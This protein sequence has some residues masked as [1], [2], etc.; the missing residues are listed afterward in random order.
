MGLTLTDNTISDNVSAFV[1]G[2]TVTAG[3][4]HDIAITATSEPTIETVS[5]VGAASLGLGGAA[6]GGNSKTTIEGTTQAYIDGGSL[7]ADGN[8]IIVSADATLVADPVIR[9]LTGGAVAVSDMISD[10]NIAGQTRAWVGGATTVTADQFDLLA[11]DQTTATP[12]TVIRGVGGASVSLTNSLIDITRETL[13]EIVSGANINTGSAQLNV[14]ATSNTFGGSETSSKT[15]SAISISDLVV[16]STVNNTTRAEIQSGAT[17]RSSGGTVLVTSISD[18]LADA[19]IASIDNGF[20]LSAN[21]TTTNAEVIGATQA[22][23]NGNVVGVNPGERAANVTVTATADELATAGSEASGGGF[24]SI[25][26]ADVDADVSSVVEAGGGGTILVSGNVTIQAFSTTDADAS[27]KSES[28][29]IKGVDISDLKATASADPNVSTTIANNAV[30]EAGG[31]L[32]VSATHGELP[33]PTSDGSFNAASNVNVG[34]DIIDVDLPHGLLTGETVTYDASEGTVIGG[35]EDGRTYGVITTADDSELQLGATFQTAGVDTLSDV[36][37]FNAPHNLVT[38][39]RVIYSPDGGSGVGGLTSGATYEVVV[40]DSRS[41]KL[42]DNP[43]VVPRPAPARNFSGSEI[44]ANEITLAGHGFT[45]GQAVTYR[46][47]GSV[48][49]GLN[50]VDVV[51]GPFN[52]TDPTA[53]TVSAPDNDNIFLGQNH[54]LVAGDEVIYTAEAGNPITG[55]TSGERYFVIFD[56]LKPDEIQ[57]AETYVLAVGDPG[58]PTAEPVV[59]P[60]PVTPI[61][62]ARSTAPADQSTG[63]SLRKVTDQPIGG[64]TDGVTYYVTGLDEEAEETD[65]TFRL[66]TNSAG[67]NLVTLGRVDPGASTVVLTGTS[68]LGTEGIDLTNAGSGGHHLVLDLSSVGSGFQLLD[69]VGGARALAGAPSGDGVVTASASGGGGGVVSSRNA[70]TSSSNTP[71]VIASIGNG[72]SLMGHDIS[73]NAVAFGNASASAANGGGGVVSIGDAESDLTISSTGQVDIGSATLTAGNNITIASSTSVNGSVLASSDGGGLIDKADA[74]VDANIFYTSTVDIGNAAELV[75]GNQ[76]TVDSNSATNVTAN[77]SGDSKGLGSSASTDADLT[78]GKSS[79]QRAVTRTSLGANARLQADEIAVRASVTELVA[80]ATAE[81]ESGGATAGAF[82]EAPIDVFDTVTVTMASGAALTAE[83]VTMSAEHS[84]VS[85]RSRSDADTNGLYANADSEAR[86]NYDSL[87]EVFTAS[88]STVAAGELNVASSQTVK[89]Y[90]RSATAD[91][92]ALGKKTTDTTGGFDP[93]RTIDWNGDVTFLADPTPELEIAANGDIVVAEGVTVN[94]VATGNVSGTL[95]LSP[96][97]NTDGG[98][99]TFT[100]NDQVTAPNP[101]F[102]FL[103]GPTVDPGVITGAG[104]T[105]GSGSTFPRVRITNRSNN[106]LVI[107]DISLANMSDVPDVSLEADIVN[108]TFDVGN[109]APG[110]DLE[111]L[112]LNEGTGDIRINGLIDNPSGLIRIE[113]QGGGIVSND[114][115]N[116]ILRGQK[117]DLISATGIGDATHRLNAELVASEGRATDFAAQAA[118]DIRLNLTGRV[119]DTNSSNS[120][121]DVGQIESTAGDV[122]LLLQSVLQ[123]TE[124][125]GSAV[126]VSVKVLAD[127]NSI[128]PAVTF[129]ERFRDFPAMEAA[130]LDI[131]LFADTTKATPIPGSYSFEQITGANIALN[132]ADSASDDPRVDVTANTNHADTGQI[133]ALVNGDLTLTETAGDA[134][135]QSIESTAG[136]IDLTVA[137]GGADAVFVQTDVGNIDLDALG[138]GVNA[139]FVQTNVGNI[140]VDALGGGVNAVFVQTNIGNIHVDALGGGVNADFIRASVD[141]DI[142]V[143]AMGD[144]QVDVIAALDGDVALTASGADSAMIYDL[145]VV[146]DTTTYV[147]GNNITLTAP[148]NIGTASNFLEIDSNASDPDPQGLV[149]ASTIYGGIFMTE[150][151][152]DLNLGRVVSA[153]SDVSLTTLGGSI[154]DGNDDLSADI[155]ARNID[156]VANGGGVGAGGNDVD[157]YGAG[158]NKQNNSLEIQP[159]A[160]AD[161]RLYALADSSIYLQ[162]VNATLDVMRVE[163]KQGDVNLTVHDTTDAILGTSNPLPEDFNLLSGDGV[164]LTGVLVDDGGRVIAAGSVLIDAGDDVNIPLDTE[165]EASSSVTIRGDYGGVLGEERDQGIGSTITIAGDVRAPSVVIEGGNDDEADFI[166]ILGTA[167]INAGGTTTLKGNEGNDRFF[168]QGTQNAL[169]LQGDAG[170]DRYYLTSNAAKDLFTGDGFF[171]DNLSDAEVFAQ[172]NGT[173]DTIAATVTVE[174]GPGGNGGTR[175]IVYASTA[176]STSAVEDGVLDYDAT[177][178]LN[179]LTGLGMSGRIDVSIPNSN[180]AFLLVG[181]GSADDEFRVDGVGSKL[182]AEIFGRGGEDTLNVGVTGG[183]LT[184][185]SGIVAFHGG[186]SDDTLNVYG[187][188]TAGADSQTGVDPDQLSGISVVGLE[189]GQNSLLSTHNRFGAGYDND[190]GD[191]YPGAIYYA[192]ITRDNVAGDTIDSDV[193]TVNIHLGG[194]D[195]TFVVD[196]VYGY[197][198][199]NV[200]GGEG[201]D[202]LTV[203]S[204]GIGLQ[205]NSIGRVDFVD[206]NLFLDGQGGVDGQGNDSDAIVVDDSGDDNKNVGTYE[207]DQVSGLDMTG[208]I[209]FADAGLIEIRLGA[210]DDTFYVPSTSASLV[211]TLMTGGNNDTVYVGTTEG[212]ESS[213]SLDA[214]AGDFIIEGQGPEV[215]DTLFLNDQDSNS[216]QTY[217]VSNAIT[218]SRTLANGSLWPIDTTTVHRT[219][220]ANIYYRTMET[221]VLN[222]GAGADVINLEG[223]HREQSVL[224][225]KASSFAVNA[226]PGDD[227]INI[228]EP[229]TGGRSLANFALD[230]SVPTFE[231]VKGIP[232]MVN[233]QDDE[234]NVHFFDDA[235][236]LSTNLAFAQRQFDE[237]FPTAADFDTLPLPDSGLN[238]RLENLK[239]GDLVELDADYAIPDFDTSPDTDV[240]PPAKIRSLSFGEVVRIEDSFAGPGGTV[241]SV[242]KFLGDAAAG[243]DLDLSDQDYTDPLLWVEVGGDAGWV[244]EYLGVDDQQLDLTIQNYGDTAVWERSNYSQGF[245]EQFTQIFGEDPTLFPYSTVVLSPAAEVS[246]A[247]DGTVPNKFTL[248]NNGTGGTFDLTI[249]GVPAGSVELLDIPFDVS[250]SVLKGLLEA[251]SEFTVDVDRSDSAVNSWTIEF[252]SPSSVLEISANAEKLLS[253]APINVNARTSETISVSLGSGDDVVQLTDGVYP[254][255][256]TVFAGAGQDTFNVEDGVDLDGNQAV[257]YGQDDDDI[258]FADFEAGVPQ[259]ALDVVF[260]GGTNGGVGDR[261]R[262]AGDGLTAGGTYTPNPLAVDPRAGTLQIAGN[263]FELIEVEPVVVHGLPDFQVVTTDDVADLDVESVDIDTLDLSTLKLQLVSIDGVI[264]WTQEQ[265]LTAPRALGAA[266]HR[267]RGEP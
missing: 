88:G 9:G 104:G 48:E 77:A 136:D 53:N 115:T 35:L 2:S 222:A 151:L 19:K 208:S 123:E 163:S 196:S 132:A 75:A 36:L 18:G 29:Y 152:G 126:G 106:P 170:A 250:G 258:L 243:A 212:N 188:A 159:G 54:G 67:T 102:A 112:I 76:I 181:L 42:I 200:F 210:Q 111:V 137:N 175:D 256:I 60:T 234:D 140:H 229:V 63:L 167:G 173:L 238:T 109:L 231:S 221:V 216:S 107:Q 233:G 90:S 58:V 161:G 25:G 135:F 223:T 51:G 93:G 262:I 230:L 46:A 30:I 83:T 120:H 186:A 244:Y 138:G 253:A 193:E 261:F 224:G 94:G 131:L 259:D 155:Q 158:R 89:R 72:A 43:D 209:T 28:G 141:G 127:E 81:A 8:D 6:A 205:P 79:S 78:I 56:P 65:N 191:A 202:T 207:G 201:A 91:I 178:D 26:K 176:G 12:S 10:A 189:M 225:G 220:T 172:L 32:T 260:H 103:S 190:L 150:I 179:S 47:P 265:K 228:G 148:G 149:S 55:L 86:V 7:I 52:T 226:G 24:V 69:G 20:G 68:T 87:N 119:R 45:N 160:P 100:V 247:P 118:D 165:V 13:A 40:I 182:A 129:V 64:L 147:Q 166:Q 73:V 263:Q 218:G 125:T 50:S 31:T 16:N 203:K 195:D 156:L 185:V 17:V 248:S 245:L 257:F 85:L 235:S 101:F 183:S 267:Q 266:I 180:T 133:T 145:D 236:A 206:G 143:N 37:T 5:T 168:V 92:D 252:T 114:G 187:N 59:P 249:T 98:S 177:T 117:I 99:A 11:A 239:K 240:D 116:D 113:N 14:N 108:L 146:D 254:T 15:A 241:D 197:G 21:V 44:T 74:D 134:L 164:T 130:P 71:T 22:L 122:D 194:G 82:A 39:D 211:T 62:L 213:G 70:Q 171:D 199:T 3:G 95:L 61:P 184:N 219:G 242:Y 105:F 121:F 27:S 169:T 124:S 227:T 255:G 214:I 49:F 251:F 154:L 215:G 192:T 97:V 264:S 23:V 144:I 33:A 1:A 174:T 217:T 66:A 153:Q 237:L 96:I 128:D 4:D 34:T 157:I 139:V 232:V 246:V 110:G 142:N 162:E 41:I 84:G 57:L 38:G 204:T 80:N 198:Q